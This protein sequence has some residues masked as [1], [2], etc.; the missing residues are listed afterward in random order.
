MHELI[1]LSEGK[2]SLCLTKSYFS[3]LVYVIC[4]SSVVKVGSHTHIFVRVWVFYI[5]KIT[6]PVY[7]YIFLDNQSGFGQQQQQT[8][9][10]KRGWNPFKGNQNENINGGPPRYG[11]R[12][13]DN[14]NN[15]HSNGQRWP[16]GQN[17]FNRPQ[18]RFGGP[19][20]FQNRPR[21]GQNQA[22]PQ[23]GGRNIHHQNN[24]RPPVNNNFPNMQ[25]SGQHSFNGP[26]SNKP[27]NVQGPPPMG[28][29]G[30]GPRQGQNGP[31]AP[32]NVDFS[33]PPPQFQQDNP[34]RPTNQP[35]GMN[36]WAGP[37]VGMPQQN[38]PFIATKIPNQTNQ[39]FSQGSQS[40]NQQQIN[41]GNQ[42]YSQGQ[43]V[44][45]TAFQGNQSNITQ[46]GNASF[47]NSVG[48]FL[49]YGMNNGQNTF[50]QQVPNNFQQNQ[51]NQFLTNNNFSGQS[52]FSNDAGKGGMTGLNF[53]P[54]VNGSGQFAGLNSLSC[55]SQPSS[56]QGPKFANFQI[57]NNPGQT[58]F[59]QLQNSE[60][61]NLVQ[62]QNFTNNHQP[63]SVQSN[64]TSNQFVTP[65]GYGFQSNPVQNQ[66]AGQ[67]GFHHGASGSYS[68]TNFV[69]NGSNSGLNQM[70]GTVQSGVITDKRFIQ[71]NL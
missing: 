54:A 38:A 13:Q 9:H 31:P 26:R 70:N 44:N 36:P 67:V 53:A 40:I 24:W 43:P 60:N 11:G 48:N 16:H 30:F 59:N 5:F 55:N 34:V 63:G 4:I 69:P 2:F 41:T 58:G 65:Q 56:T 49:N 10:P 27:F 22:Q 33:Q 62:N 51:P 50:N 21:M 25:N 17:N 7:I 20:N 12:H 8:H 64:N 29:Q 32:V 46:T 15:S 66:S 3:S 6:F 37:Q 18:S 47:Q 61:T 45:S 52:N 19:P 71:N 1:I 39:P 42:M 35:A 23:Y 14:Q 57:Q 68:G 28:T